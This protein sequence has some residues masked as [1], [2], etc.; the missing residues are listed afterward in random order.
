MNA[1]LLSLA[2]EAMG[3]DFGKMAAQFLGESP[4]STQSA[5]SAL[6]PA[7]LGSIARRARR[8]TAPRACCR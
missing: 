8:P 3:G 2:Q 4:E 1:N 5:M 6:L 7:V